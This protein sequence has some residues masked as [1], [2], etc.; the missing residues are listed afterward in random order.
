VGQNEIALDFGRGVELV[1]VPA[2]RDREAVVE[3]D[4]RVVVRGRRAATIDGDDATRVG[5]A[6]RADVG[7]VDE[8][9]AA[10]RPRDTVADGGASAPARIDATPD[11]VEIGTSGA[12]LVLEGGDAR[13]EA[14]RAHVVADEIVVSGR[15]RV[16]VAGGGDVVVE[17]A[18][19]DVVVQG[20]PMVLINPRDARPEA[21]D[22][23]SPFP[24]APPHGVDPIENV[25]AAEDR[26]HHDPAR[27][28]WLDDR[29]EPGGLWHFASDPSARDFHFAHEGA[30]ARA[31]GR[32]RSVILRQAGLRR[33]RVRAA[34]AGDASLGDP[35]NGL[36]GGRAPF[37]NDP[38]ELALLEQGIDWYDRNFGAGG[39]G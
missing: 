25:E 18:G 26:M 10:A 30:V 34:S 38:R 6:R 11:R 8:V 29:L 36:W 32:P 35:G 14:T 15:T 23:L 5:A 21:D 33:A 37:G 31:S 39:G 13:L 20:G 19:G 24:V 17:S 2:A 3:S 4:D 1:Y 28:A 22:D 27:P 12:R 7:T 9:R 16:R